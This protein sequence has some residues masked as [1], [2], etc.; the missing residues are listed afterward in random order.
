VRGERK[1]PNGQKICQSGGRTAGPKDSGKI[2]TKFIGARLGEE[3]QQE[4][5]SNDPANPERTV[6][7][8]I[9]A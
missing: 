9:F 1:L 5:L 4:F 2:E 3:Q 7:S 8:R 6:K